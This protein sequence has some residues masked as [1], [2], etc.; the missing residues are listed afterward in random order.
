MCFLHVQGYQ[1][2]IKVN[3]ESCVEN[4]LG[5]HFDYGNV[6]IDQ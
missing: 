2:D 5:S 4:N 1:F 6:V 3:A